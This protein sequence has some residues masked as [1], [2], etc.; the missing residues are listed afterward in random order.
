MDT[1]RN[2]IKG[3]T[4]LITGVAGFI[5]SN[6]AKRLL[7]EGY[8]VIGIDNFDPFYDKA[9]KTRQLQDLVVFK[10]SFK[11]YEV[12]IR[13][14][15]AL[16]R[17]EEKVDLVVHLAA[18]AG[19]LPS[20][21]NPAEYIAVNIEGTFNVLEMMRIKHIQK[22]VFASSSSIYG[23][24]KNIPFSEDDNVDHPISPYAFTK[25]SCELANYNYHHLYKMDILN[26]RFFTVYG[27]GQRPDLAIH[28]FVKLIESGKSIEMYGDGSSARDYTYIDDIVDGICKS[29]NYLA[30]HNNVYEVINIG[31]NNPVTLKELIA[32]L[33][34]LLKKEYAVQTKPMQAGDVDITYANTRKAKAL[35]GYQPNTSLADG[36]TK[37]I[38][39]YKQSPSS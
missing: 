1:I 34:K 27:P 2:M 37:F 17:I 6:L 14:K 15:E 20:I 16:G 33:F 39:W 19:V 23:N 11:F 10:D 32:T 4:I 29:L 5:G 8:S 12:D 28:K 22:M 35:L 38:E 3:S 31:N 13:S 24:N 26:L 30:E 25:K 36:L 9:I 18:K 21:E 7:T